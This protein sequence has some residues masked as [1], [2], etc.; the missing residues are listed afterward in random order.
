[1]KFDF[2]WELVI[3][4]LLP[5]NY[6]ITKMNWNKLTEA[7][8]IQEIKTLSEQKPVMIFKHSTRCSISSMSLDRLIRKWKEM[9]SEKVTPYYL[10]LIASRQL[11]DLV[12]KE[13][14]IPHESPQVLL[15]KDGK[16]I[17][18]AS[19]FDISYADL[20]ERI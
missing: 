9:D 5:Q 3:L 6:K 4:Q 14:L 13:F 16:V 15:I 11:S 1:M 12:A 8:Q 10:D 7:S 20:L 2:E 17:H 18:T 19:H